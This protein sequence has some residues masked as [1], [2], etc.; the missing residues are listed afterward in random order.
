M[1]C[2]VM[3]LPCWSAPLR[4][5]LYARIALAAQPDGAAM[6]MA[7]YAAD[8]LVAKPKSAALL[9]DWCSSQSRLA[10]PQVLLH[11]W[12]Q[13]ERRQGLCTEVGVLADVDWPLKPRKADEGWMPE[14]SAMYGLRD[15]SAR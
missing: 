14:L 8:M 13:E 7:L 15:N 4:D 12:R 11:L 5:A 1:G 9:L 2:P 10:A 3:Q 6:L